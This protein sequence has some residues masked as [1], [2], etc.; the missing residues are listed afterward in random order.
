MSI[1]RIAEG[2]FQI[3]GAGGGYR[4]EKAQ[5]PAKGR[6]ARLGG[7]A[8]GKGGK[9]SGEGKIVSDWGVI[10]VGKRG[11]RS[12]E[13]KIRRDWG[14]IAPDLVPL[15]DACV[16]NWRM[17]LYPAWLHPDERWSHRGGAAG[18]AEQRRRGRR[19]E[20]LCHRPPPLHGPP[21][22]GRG[23][24]MAVG[25]GRRGALPTRGAGR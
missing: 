25:F 20:R 17:K 16:P 10:A 1:L 9:R 13:G 6:S 3:R 19:D 23:N 4:A 22:A 8:V 24:Q 11:T 18:G 14:V 5:G 7:I 21:G 12:G 15:R 2:V